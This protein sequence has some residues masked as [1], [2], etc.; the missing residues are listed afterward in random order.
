VIF[1]E[2]VLSVNLTNL[3]KLSNNLLPDAANPVVSE[4]SL[5]NVVRVA[6]VQGH[7]PGVVG[8]VRSGSSRPIGVVSAG[9]ITDTAF[10]RA[11]NIGLH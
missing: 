9:Q 5:S 11:V 6:V 8:I 1:F 7:A 4:A 2:S 10:S 3:A